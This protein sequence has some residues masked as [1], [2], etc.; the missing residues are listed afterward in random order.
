MILRALA[1][2]VLVAGNLSVAFAQQ[3][4]SVATQRLSANGALFLAAMR[5]YFGAEGLDLTMGAY[6]S[7]FALA[8]LSPAAFNLAGRG[9]IKAVAAQ[10]REW[11]DY[12]GDEVI[13][14][15]A[16]YAHGLRKFADLA[17]KVVAVDALGS[18]VHFQLGEIARAKGFKLAGVTVKPLYS[19][20]DMAQAVADGTVDAAVLPSRYARDLLVANQGRLIGWCSEIGTPQLGALFVSA[21]LIRTQHEMVEKFVRAYARGVADYAKALLRHDRYGKRVSDTAAK[22]AAADIARYVYPDSAAGA[23]TVA[24]NAYYIDPKARLDA[25]DFARQLVWYEAQGFVKK[26]V[27]AGEIVDSE[28][29]R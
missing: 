24:A 3:P 10:T 20:D 22:Q 15:N 17:G 28:F 19:F 12:E 29:F 16:A 27:M 11:R 7:Q 6:P 2:L 9:V 8:A 13:A 26:N 4:V 25:K 5:G 23:V 1:I 18:P 21:K 14:A